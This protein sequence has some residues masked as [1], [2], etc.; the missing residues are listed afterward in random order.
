V[1]ATHRDLRALAAEG[2]F[3]EDLYY[4]LNVVCVH[5]PPLAQRPNDI[6]LLVSTFLEQLNDEHHRR[7]RT[8]SADAM[9]AL[10]T[11]HWPGNVR[12]LHNL[13]EG[14]VVLS[15]KGVVDVDDLPFEIHNANAPTPDRHVRARMT[16]PELERQAIQDCLL[17]TGG[18]RQRAAHLLG[19]SV[20]TLIRK[21]QRYKLQDPLRTA[22]TCNGK[23]SRSR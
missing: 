15:C 8:V 17:E 21:I 11:Y 13:L 20:R 14:I 7:V 12:E 16:L 22:A 19:I 4:R 23:A 1:A 5:L 10:Q 6:P 3:R 18:K 2:R 9:H